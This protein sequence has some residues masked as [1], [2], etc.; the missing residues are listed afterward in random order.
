MKDKI[1]FNL[2]VLI[3]TTLFFIYANFDGF[4]EPTLTAFLGTYITMFIISMLT[5]P[6]T[7]L[8]I[9]ILEI[10]SNFFV[11]KQKVI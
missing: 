1:L 11:K 5:L 10:F 8:E 2:V 4:Y 6:I 3:H 7:A 9:Y